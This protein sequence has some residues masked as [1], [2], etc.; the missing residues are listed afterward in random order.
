MLDVVVLHDPSSEIILPGYGIR[1]NIPAWGI[2]ETLYW[3]SLRVHYIW[4]KGESKGFELRIMAVP[5]S[6]GSEDYSNVLSSK[7]WTMDSE[8]MF[9]NVSD[10]IRK[11][12]E[13]VETSASNPR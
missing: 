10:V 9:K 4:G 3:R 12:K 7:T 2:P 11:R 8:G 5:A 1:F 6:S 13:R